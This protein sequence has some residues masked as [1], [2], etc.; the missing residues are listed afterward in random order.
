[1]LWKPHPTVVVTSKTSPT[2]WLD[3]VAGNVTATDRAGRSVERSRA[4]ERGGWRGRVLSRP[5]ARRALS[6]PTRETRTLRP[7]TF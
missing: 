2:S 5:T 7:C 6:D 3:L 1:M 4:L